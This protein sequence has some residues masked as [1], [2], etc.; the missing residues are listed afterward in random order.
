MNIK[1]FIIASIAV[2]FV[3][4]IT[5]PLIHGVF[6]GKAYEASKH[7]WRPNMM[8]K[9]WIM[10]LSTFV[11]SFLFVYVFTK[12]YEE[13]GIFEGIRFGLLIGIFVYIYSIVNQYVVYPLPF[14]F[15]L[16]W[17]IFGL[18]QFAILGIV[19]SL[20]YKSIKSS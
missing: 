13:K 14:T 6:L 9:M 17:G 11:F 15:I 3:I 1:R 18:I 12:G 16:K 8:S 7:L 4:Q 10:M 20:I 5:D 19:A 2:F